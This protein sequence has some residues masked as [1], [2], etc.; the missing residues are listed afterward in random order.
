MGP[1]FMM[2]VLGMGR[3]W[4]SGVRLLL[5]GRSNSINLRNE[6]DVFYH[7]SRVDVVV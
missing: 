7:N 3:L 1:S 2:I 4:T 6:V 5:R